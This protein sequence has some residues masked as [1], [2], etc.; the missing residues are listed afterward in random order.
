MRVWAVLLV[1]S[2]A[3]QAG[4]AELAGRVVHVA[5][6]DTIT[7]LDP[8]R[9]QHVVRLAGI[10]APER[11]QAFGQV[12]RRHLMDML[13]GQ[14]V[15]VEW[16]KRDRYGRLVGKVHWSGVDANLA[17]VEAGV[18]WHYTAYEAE[19][20]EHDRVVYSLAQRTAKEARRG[21]WRESDPVAPWEWRRAARARGPAEGGA[22]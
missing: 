14:S 20:S 19:Q 8:E 21:L 17:Q 7:V 11:G 3:F 1:L 22:P 4:A 6:G 18:A 10:D 15:E 9:V 5:D 12:A 13:L 16:H 2:I